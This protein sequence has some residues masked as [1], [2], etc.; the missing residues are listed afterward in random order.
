MDCERLTNILIKIKTE[1][2]MLGI[3]EVFD[4][5]TQRAFTCSNVTIE[6]VEL[7][8]EYVQS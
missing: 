6:T 8:V 3:I 1:L 7:N 2:I 5:R 4:A